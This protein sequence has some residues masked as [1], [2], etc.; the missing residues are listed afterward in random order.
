M[1]WVFR[2]LSLVALLLVEIEGLRGTPAP[3]LNGS[4]LAV[5]IALLGFMLGTSATVV[6]FEIGAS[7]LAALLGVLVVSSGALFWLQ[8]DGPGIM[9]CFIAAAVA[10]LRLPRWRSA[11]VMATALTVLA[12]PAAISNGHSLD[13][14]ALNLAGVAAFY[15]MGELARRLRE[16]QELASRLLAELEKSHAARIE[17]A[18]LDERQRLAREM[19][20]VLAH[21]LSG[22]VLQLEAV[23]L[24]AAHGGADPE[25][26]DAID[27]SV[28]LGKSGVAEARQAIGMLRGD[29]LPGPDALAALVDEFERGTS[30]RCTFDVTGLE[31]PLN[32]S[33]RLTLYRVAQEA[34][35]NVRRHASPERVELRLGYEV[36]GTRLSI[37]DFSVD[38]TQSSIGGLDSTGGYGITGMR[39]RAELLGGRLEARP[40]ERGFRVEL[41]VPV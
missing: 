27:R 1:V 3:S 36:E 11:A 38:G 28:Q 35:T 7:G 34:L 17:A 19:H 9:G 6:T 4:G 37:E 30:V 12:A 40:T 2:G 31:R 5:T 15:T 18:T 8:P 22:L 41:W 26:H 16:G 25:L 13:S 14:V 29:E 23:R 39:E 24:L 21:S 10:A 20:D 32:S 33:T